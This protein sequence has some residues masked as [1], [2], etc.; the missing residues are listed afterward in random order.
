M[1]LI[2][3]LLPPGVVR[4]NIIQDIVRPGGIEGVFSKFLNSS[5]NEL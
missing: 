1:E 4:R 5:G 3:D 2:G